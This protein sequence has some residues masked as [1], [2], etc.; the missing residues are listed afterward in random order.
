MKLIC[1]GDWHLRERPPEARRDDYFQEQNKKLDWV[2]GL[3]K[4]EGAAIVQP[5]D[6]FNSNPPTE[7]L[8]Q[9]VIRKITE[10][11]LRIYTVFGQHD[12]LHHSLQSLDRTGLSVLEAAG[13]VTILNGRGVLLVKE[14]VR[15]VGCHW[16]QEVPR[17]RRREGVTTVLVM[18]RMVIKEP[19]WP[20]Q[21][22]DDGKVLLRK[23]PE[24]D[25]IITGDNHQCFMFE[26]GGRFLF[27]AG[28]LMRMTASQFAHEPTVGIYDTK[29]R[30]FR[31]VK[32]PCGP[33][34]KV[35]SREHIEVVGERDERLRKFIESLKEDYE[36][37]LSFRD[38]LQQFFEANK[39]EQSIQDLIWENM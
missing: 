34:E 16:G 1:T 31:T 26:S 17:L 22:A 13:V 2:F 39:V 6:F 11:G 7:F 14:R 25:L 8:K 37:G 10:K 21:Q 20:G 27:N 12:L 33:S 4:R 35:L 24:Y 3:A 38:N 32:I 18:H 23:Y 36:V 19:L 28:S 30:E 29:G 15:L 5:G 9:W